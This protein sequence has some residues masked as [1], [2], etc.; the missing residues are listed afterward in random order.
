M[1]KGWGNEKLHRSAS[2]SAVLGIE[3]TAT[4]QAEPLKTHSMTE[5]VSGSG[6]ER[7]DGWT[8]SD[9]EH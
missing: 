9:A 1:G 8:C 7:D 5:R 6:G 2:E 3:K 4:C